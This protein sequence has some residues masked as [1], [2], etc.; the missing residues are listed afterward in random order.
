MLVAQEKGIVKLIL[1][2]NKRGLI[3]VNLSIKSYRRDMK[4]IDGAFSRCFI[5]EE[6]FPVKSISTCSFVRVHYR[7][8]RYAGK[9]LG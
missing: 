2:Y 7:A 8:F 5:A 3:A 4:P 9:R 6:N 1:R